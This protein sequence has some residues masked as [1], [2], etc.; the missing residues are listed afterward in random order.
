MLTFFWPFYEFFFYYS[1]FLDTC[2]RFLLRCWLTWPIIDIEKQT[3]NEKC[4][5]IDH[6]KLFEDKTMV[7]NLKW[8]LVKINHYLLKIVRKHHNFFRFEICLNMKS[9][10]H[11]GLTQCTHDKMFI[12]MHWG[13]NLYFQNT[14]FRAS[15]KI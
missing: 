15:S 9:Y 6:V 5:N 7:D 11:L 14:Y 12:R 10:L 1:P 8:I 13:Q 4:H 3:F 2:I